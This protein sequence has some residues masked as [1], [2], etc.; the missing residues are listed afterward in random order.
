VM[1][2]G[3]RTAAQTTT[4]VAL[5]PDRG[6]GAQEGG[7]YRALRQREGSHNTDARLIA[8]GGRPGGGEERKRCKNDHVPARVVNGAMMIH[9]E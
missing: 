3:R 7:R 9:H 2:K 5:R 6:G 1:D 8:G 4:Q